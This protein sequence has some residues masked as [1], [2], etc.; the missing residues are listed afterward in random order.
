MI[1]ARQPDEPLG[2]LLLNRIGV[3]DRL[4]GRAARGT[5][6]VAG[7]PVCPPVRVRSPTCRQQ[8]DLE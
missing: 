3:D 6:G 8:E 5:P 1:I 2:S 4:G 7:V